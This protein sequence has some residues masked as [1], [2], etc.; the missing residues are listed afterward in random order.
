MSTAAWAQGDPR[1]MSSIETGFQACI[2]WHEQR[3]M[4]PTKTECMNVHT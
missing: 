2:N 3:N 1:F 4:L